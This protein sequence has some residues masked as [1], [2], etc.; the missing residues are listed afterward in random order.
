M[1]L[2]E[3]FASTIRGARALA[4]A[5]LR[6]EILGVLH[7]GLSLSGLTQ[8]DTAKSLGIRRS[9]VNQVF[10]GDGNLRVN[11]IADY[12]DTMG[13][14][15]DVRLVRAGEPRKATMEKRAQG[16]AVPDW[17]V[18][19]PQQVSTGVFSPD[20]VNDAHINV[21]WNRITDMPIAAYS[22]PTTNPAISMKLEAVS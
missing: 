7:Q 20:S 21:R 2:Y 6:H 3:R 4:A 9:A 12:L 10:R 16:L 19:A 18:Q 8:S 13:F 22:P 15:L 17:R 14:E 5:R 1:S 11:T